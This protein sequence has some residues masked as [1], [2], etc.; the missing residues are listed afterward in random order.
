MNSVQEIVLLNKLHCNYSLDL[1]YWHGTYFPEID[2]CDS[3]PCKNGGNC[4][5]DMGKYVC[6]C[7]PGYTGLNCDIGWCDLWPLSHLPSPFLS[8]SCCQ[9]SWSLSTSILFDQAGITVWSLC[10]VYISFFKFRFTTYLN[11][12][13]GRT[14]LLVPAGSWQYTVFL[15][16]SLC[17]RA[18]WYYHHNLFHPRDV[19]SFGYFLVGW[20]NSMMDIRCL[21]CKARKVLSIAIL[22]HVNR[23]Y[24]ECLNG[25]RYMVNT[26]KVIGKNALS[27]YHQR[28]YA[29]SFM[30]VILCLF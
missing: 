1:L 8:V 11:L 27:H 7:V 6:S 21:N 26:L 28:R 16:K 9:S 17:I 23:R 19:C 24:L 5:Q 14:L 15:R 29:S 22:I 12:N 3:N 2:I 18:T 20:L 4:T 13:L 25:N 10:V 30:F